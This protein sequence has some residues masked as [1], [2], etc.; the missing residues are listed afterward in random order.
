MKSMKNLFEHI[1]RSH[2][3]AYNGVEE[4]GNIHDGHP[5]NSL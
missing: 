5:L 1:D 4:Q 2:K 3:Y